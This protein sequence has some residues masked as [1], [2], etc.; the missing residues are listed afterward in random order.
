MALRSRVIRR[1]EHKRDDHTSRVNAKSIRRRSADGEHLIQSN[2]SLVSFKELYND[3]QNARA[4]L[5]PW[6]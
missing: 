6:R 2:D 5:P 3:S 1:S 4:E